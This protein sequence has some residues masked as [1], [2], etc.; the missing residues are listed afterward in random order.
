MGFLCMAVKQD[1]DGNLKMAHAV[2]SHMALVFGIVDCRCTELL[3]SSVFSHLV[4]GIDKSD[5][6]VKDMCMF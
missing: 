2:C 4:S 3:L 5:G 1:L 6:I